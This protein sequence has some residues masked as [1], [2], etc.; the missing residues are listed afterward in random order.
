M[1]DVAEVAKLTPVCLSSLGPPPSWLRLLTTPASPIILAAM[2]AVRKTKLPNDPVCSSACVLLWS[3]FSMLTPSLVRPCC[4][5]TTPELL[6]LP[7]GFRIS[8]NTS[9]NVVQGL[10]R[11]TGYVDHVGYPDSAPTAKEAKAHLCLVFPELKKQTMTA[12]IVS[13][14]FFLQRCHPSLVHEPTVIVFRE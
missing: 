14:V 4:Q 12:Q 7:E 2:K 11:L 3:V 6:P 10:A 8:P 5:S 13:P 1:E 9:D